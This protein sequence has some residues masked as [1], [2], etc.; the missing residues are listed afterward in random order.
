MHALPRTFSWLTDLPF[1]NFLIE[2][3]FPLFTTGPNFISGMNV[4]IQPG[5]AK[6]MNDFSRGDILSS[7]SDQKE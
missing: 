1:I 4:Q 7:D 2:A 6:S 3:P 5:T